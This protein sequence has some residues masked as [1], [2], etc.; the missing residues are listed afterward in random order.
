LI[1]KKYELSPSIDGVT[2][3][4]ATWFFFFLFGKLNAK[5]ETTLDVEGQ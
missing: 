1:S 4:D 3:D 2:V 5:N